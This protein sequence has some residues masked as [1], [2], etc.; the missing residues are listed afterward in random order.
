MQ[1]GAA[2]ACTASAWP[3]RLQIHLSSAAAGTQK[4]ARL[5]V[6]DPARARSSISMVISPCLMPHMAQNHHGYVCF[7]LVWHN[8]QGRTM[9]VPLLSL[10]ESKA[11]ARL[12]LGQSG[13][14]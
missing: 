12:R 9:G 1:S 14:Q 13:K 5:A 11:Q 6:Q 10:A 2:E 3:D 4:P 7:Q 8:T